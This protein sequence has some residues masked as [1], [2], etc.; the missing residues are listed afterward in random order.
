VTR[1]ES[2]ARRF[3]RMLRLPVRLAVLWLAGS[4][5]AVLLLRFVP[6]IA[7]SVQIYDGWWRLVHGQSPFLDARWKPYGDIADH[8]KL[9]VIA[10][11]DQKFPTHYGFDL[12]S[13]A[14][15]LERH[16][17]GRRRL[18]GASTITQQVAKNLFL[19]PE[20]SWLRKGI[21]AYYAALLEALWPKQRIL[22]M[23]LNVAE[24]GDGIYGVEAAGQ[25]FFDRPA[26]RLNREQ[27]SLL[28]A[29]LPNPRRLHAERPSAYVRQRAAWV[30]GQMTA[31]GGAAYLRPFE[32]RW[33]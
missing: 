8:A 26:A 6:P 5:I 29:V 1:T 30:R 2:T 17:R 20:R 16:Q 15:A 28:A 23:Y 25:R 21:E 24:L 7:S 4:V 12:E 3:G 11:E 27:A 31:L 22:E 19:W 10:A 32:G 9:A 33:F 13:M 18:R 14:D